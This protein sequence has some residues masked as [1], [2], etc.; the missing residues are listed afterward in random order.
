MSTSTNG[1]RPSTLVAWE[2][3]ILTN[4]TVA[5]VLR[6][7]FANWMGL[8]AGRHR[9]RLIEDLSIPA[10]DGLPLATDRYEP[11]GVA[12]GPTILMRTPYSKGAAGSVVAGLFAYQF[13]THGY[14]VVVQDCRGRFG[15]QGEAGGE[16][17]P[18]LH[19][20]EDGAV[21]LNWIA[22]QAWSD[23]Q[24][25]M[26]GASYL[27]YCQ[28]AA[29]STGSPH[30]KALAPLITSSHLMSFPENGFP[31]DLLLRWMFQMQTM[32]TPNL[33]MIERMKRINDATVQDRFLR[34][35]FDHLPIL[36]ADELA[37]GHPGALYR[38]MA[39]A[40]A[41]HEYWHVADH[42]ATVAAA[43]PANLTSGWYDL[44]LDGLL[45]D[46]TAQQ[47]AAQAGSKPKPYLTIGPWHHLDTGYLPV[48]FTESLA[49]FSAHLRGDPSKLRKRPVR[50][51]V[52]GAKR[53]RSF[54][55]WP[56][57]SKEYKLYLHGSG[58]QKTG[59]LRWQP[60]DAGETAAGSPNATP[61]QYRYNP[62]LPT[63]NLGGSK[64]GTDAGQVDNRPLEERADVLVYTT[65][66]LPGDVEVI[67]Y[68]RAELYVRS[69]L[70]NTDFFVRLCDV[71]SSGRSLNVCDGNFRIEPGRGE[72][73]PDGSL[74]IP[75]SMSATAYR[76]LANH[77]IRVQVSSGAHPRFARNLGVPEPQVM[78]TT[79]MMADQTI[80][81]DAIHPSAV[82][83]PLVGV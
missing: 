6:Q 58:A 76:F 18:F 4:P 29:A 56:P 72:L 61:D 30:L 53:W 22:Q 52:M 28:W 13:A 73:Q 82:V 17:M 44:F 47:K 60:V 62:A 48:A 46:Y 3:K 26:W 2:H 71:E 34:C 25:G 45:E 41:T 65:P 50:L 67:G 81:H 14:H 5:G 20:A 9:V 42:S 11:A 43:P 59:R 31:L 35:A 57:P 49:W 39:E 19:E 8:P 36:T 77:R 21:T 1:S 33:S 68:V 64:M 24:I 79:Y 27:G 7:F 54:E 66:P 80:Y 32:D 78:S 69:S 38:E 75:I 16:F 37:I 70:A 12:V 23:G 15:S 51:F 10:A 63:P 74:R 40:D 83:L 55:S